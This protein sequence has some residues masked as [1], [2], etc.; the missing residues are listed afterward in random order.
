MFVVQQCS[1]SD[2]AKHLNAQ[3][4]LTDLG[5]PWTRAVVHQILTNE[6]YVGHNVYNRVSFKLKQ[7]RIKNPPDMLI[8]CDEAFTPIVESDFFE[9]ARRI[10]LARCKRFSNEEML[11]LLANLL[12]SRGELS[13]L[14]IDEGDDM[15]SSSAYRH[16][17]GSLVRAYKLIG[18]DPGRDFSYIETNRALRILHPRIIADITSELKAIGAEASQCGDTDILTINN[19]FTLSIVIV[20]SAATRAGR[21][22]WKIRLDAGL[23][24]DLTLAVR[25]DESN[26]QV[27]DYYLLPWIDVGAIALLRLNED[28]GVSLDSYRYD[29]LDGFLRLARRVDVRRAA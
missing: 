6:K 12:R 16:R 1:E 24:P 9:A 26:E 3:H 25:M 17:F 23:M 22:R 2:I 28:N 7:R 10:I 29:T 21:L 8:R 11:D 13:G 19:E 27:R 20:R 5:R 18:Y 14:V 4:I 15:P